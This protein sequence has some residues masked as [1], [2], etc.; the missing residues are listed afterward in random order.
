MYW[1]GSVF[2]ASST[3]SRTRL[4]SSISTF[5]APGVSDDSG[6]IINDLGVSDEPGVVEYD[7]GAIINDL[8]V[9]DDPWAITKDPG[10]SDDPVVICVSGIAI[11]CGMTAASGVA[12]SS[13]FITLIRWKPGELTELSL[14]NRRVNFARLASNT[15]FSSN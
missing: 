9:S 13:A 4:S 10:V 12:D 5:N 14:S 2:T 11:D 6:T 1:G 3:V 7:P 15:L 8:G